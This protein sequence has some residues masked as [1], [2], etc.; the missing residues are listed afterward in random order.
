MS[1]VVLLLDTL[2]AI[3]Q[4]VVGGRSFPAQSVV[5]GSSDRKAAKK[6]SRP[7][8]SAQGAKRP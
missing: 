2:K 6:I 7:W 1:R 5:E 3:S 8:A 4:I